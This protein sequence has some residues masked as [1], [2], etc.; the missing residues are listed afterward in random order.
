MDCELIRADFPAQPVDALTALAFVVTGAL[1]A[2]RRRGT[3]PVV[4]GL[5]LV[6]VGTTSFLLHGMGLD[7][8]V[9]SVA[10]VS[11]ASWVVLWATLGATS[12]TVWTWA[13]VTAG[14]GTLL[15]IA[16]DSRHVVTAIVAGVAVVL[17]VRLRS[18]KLWAALG[19]TAG[20]V[21]VYALSRTGGP[22]C[23]PSSPLQGHGLWHL[24][25][26]AVLWMVGDDLATRAN[27][28]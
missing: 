2:T 21:V 3:G 14:L 25:M 22:W 23:V 26:A 11:L 6:A 5:S 12:R 24:M 8:A 18:R 1:L 9:E 17:L 13:G 4:Y 7:G 15:S 27:S 28:G 16:P 10:V 20:A 19:L